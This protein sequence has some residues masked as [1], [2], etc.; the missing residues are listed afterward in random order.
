VMETGRM[1]LAG[2]AAP[3]GSFSAK[4]ISVLK[5]ER[6]VLAARSRRAVRWNGL[7]EEQ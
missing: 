4:S 7:A 6:A 1:S 3:V 5:P 2:G